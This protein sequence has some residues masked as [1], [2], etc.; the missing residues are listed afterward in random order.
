MFSSKAS[1]LGGDGG[2]GEGGGDGGGGEGGGDGG[3]GVGG[4]GEGGGGEGGGDGGG[5]EGGGRGENRAVVKR[6]AHAALQMLPL[7]AQ[8]PPPEQLLPWQVA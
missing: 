3:G 7:A 8:Q 6:I 4:G 5:G 1:Q 2:G